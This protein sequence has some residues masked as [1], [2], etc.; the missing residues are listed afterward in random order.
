MAICQNGFLPE[1][2]KRFQ[3]NLVLINYTT[4]C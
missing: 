1:P 3:Q 2:I 4:H